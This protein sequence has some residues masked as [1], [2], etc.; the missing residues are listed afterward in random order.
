MLAN[1]PPQGG[2]IIFPSDE[3]PLPM[4]LN[5]VLLLAL[6]LFAF[7]GNA[8]ARSAPLVD[9]APVEVPAGLTADQV[10]KE[11]KRA[12]LGRGWAV[13]GEQPG[14]IDSTL[15]LRTHTAVIRV[16]YDTRQVRLAYV[17]SNE[18]E[19]KEKKGKRSIHPNYLG[20]V[21]NVAR[22]IKINLGLKQLGD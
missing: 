19:Y 21:D 20:W 6:S 4:R 10:A 12:L 8:L 2:G 14:R 18:L 1:P 9:P 7:S 13:T 11:I 3:G 17:D 15:H 5:V 22:D 16:D